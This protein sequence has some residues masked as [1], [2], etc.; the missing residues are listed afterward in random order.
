M[1]KTKRVIFNP[2]DSTIPDKNGKIKKGW[3][4]GRSVQWIQCYGCGR[5]TYTNREIGEYDGATLFMAICTNEDCPLNDVAVC[6]ER[7][8]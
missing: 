8:G 7:E 1:A 5:R 4:W 3:G 2:Y 6:Y